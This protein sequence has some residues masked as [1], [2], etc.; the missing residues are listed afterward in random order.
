MREEDG[1]LARLASAL[2]HPARVAILRVL[3]ERGTCIC[4]E[5]VGMLPLAQ[6]T[7]SQHLK[8]LKDAG[9]IEG[10]ADGPRTC[11]CADPGRIERLRTL[12]DGMSAVLAG[13]AAAA[14]AP[15]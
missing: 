8:M 10:E 3:R 15:G 11:Y 14:A 13:R 7:V 2:G 6:S 4:G 12:L 1:E 5:I 9:W